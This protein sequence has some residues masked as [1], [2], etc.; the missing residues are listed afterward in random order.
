MCEI[1]DEIINNVEILSKLKLS[2][3]E[4]E[5]AKVDMKKMLEYIDVLKKTDTND[6]N[7]ITHFSDEINIF[8]EDE[9]VEFDE[10]QEIIKNA[11]ES[12][13]SMF[14]VPKTVI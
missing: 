7:E 10:I 14:C 13:K 4:R 8:R 11:P 1:T 2:E 5:Q 3:S 9:I 12:E 6:V